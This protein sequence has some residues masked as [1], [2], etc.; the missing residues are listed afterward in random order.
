MRLRATGM[1]IADTQRFAE[2]RGKGSSSVTDR[3]E[4]LTGHRD[5]VQRHIADLQGDLQV[6]DTKI[7]HYQ[8]L[9]DE[10]TGTDQL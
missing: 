6:L 1:S 10:Q 2:L 9:L 5:A 3:L 7:T 8:G 4:L